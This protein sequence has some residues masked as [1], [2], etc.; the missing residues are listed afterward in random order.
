LAS[1]GS[2]HISSFVGDALYSL[3]PGGETN[4]LVNFPYR[5]VWMACFPSLTPAV[6]NAGAVYFGGD[7][8]IY[9]ISRDAQPQWV[10]KSPASGSAP[11]D[12]T[13]PA[14][15]SDGTIYATLSN[16]L[17]AIAGTKP[18]R[19]SPWPMLGQNVRRTGKVE[20]PSLAQ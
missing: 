17:Y 20:K 5:C 12:M 4:W 14:I 6:D 13:S 11:V 3:K 16:V 9:S 2:I 1:D 15:G 10:V 19:D 18:A 7:N 8:S